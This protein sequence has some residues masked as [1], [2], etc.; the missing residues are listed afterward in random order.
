[1][2]VVDAVPYFGGEEPTWGALNWTYSD[3]DRDQ[4]ITAW[5]IGEGDLGDFPKID[6]A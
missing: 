2:G 4:S 6:L 5:I 3:T 1:M